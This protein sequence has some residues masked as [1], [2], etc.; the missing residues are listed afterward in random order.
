M[1][2]SG[3]DSDSSGKDGV[4]GGMC[5]LI[6]RLDS[7]HTLQILGVQAE[8]EVP[9]DTVLRFVSALPFNVT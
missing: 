1:S 9:V 7:V 5:L 2:S 6:V 4:G 3:E 8:R